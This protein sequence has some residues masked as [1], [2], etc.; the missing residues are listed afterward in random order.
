MAAILS[1]DRDSF[2]KKYRLLVFLAI[3]VQYRRIVVNGTFYVLEPNFLRSMCIVYL[4][5]AMEN[6]LGS[7]CGI[8]GL[9]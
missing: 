9:N 2:S 5:I 4:G 7:P 3:S 1:R 8:Q 6:P